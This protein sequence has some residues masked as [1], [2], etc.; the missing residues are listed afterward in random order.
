MLLKSKKDDG[1]V[2][3]ASLE[4]LIDPFQDKVTG[5][6]QAGQNEQPPEPF[7]KKD[8]IFPSG[9]NLPLCWLDS[10]YKSK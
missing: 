9:E 3:I 2:E 6:T 7:A 10:D 5:Q 4:E 8:L 1:L